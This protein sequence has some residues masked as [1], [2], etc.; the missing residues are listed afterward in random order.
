MSGKVMFGSG[1]L[2]I[3]AE[4]ESRSLLGCVRPTRDERCRAQAC[5]NIISACWSLLDGLLHRPTLCWRER[6]R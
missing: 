4:V 2:D 1:D 6:R 5:E 3:Q